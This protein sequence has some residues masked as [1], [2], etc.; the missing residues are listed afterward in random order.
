MD[1]VQHGTLTICA[2]TDIISLQKNNR[3]QNLDGS[4]TNNLDTKSKQEV[5]KPI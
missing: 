2:A 1:M 3:I 4:K 5:I